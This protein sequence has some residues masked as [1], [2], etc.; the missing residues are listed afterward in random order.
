MKLLHAFAC[1]AS[2]KAHEE[3]VIVSPVASSL[4]KAPPNEQDV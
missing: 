3:E 4:V 1:L 2:A